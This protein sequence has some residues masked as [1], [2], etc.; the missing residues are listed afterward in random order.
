MAKQLTPAER[1]VL[2]KQNIDAAT[3]VVTS[4]T[5]G[6]AAH[7]GAVKDMLD[8]IP[9]VL[10]P[11][12]RLQHARAAGRFSAP[13]SPLATPPAAYLGLQVRAAQ[14]W[15][16]A[17]RAMAAHPHYVKQVDVEI[18]RT[19][20]LSHVGSLLLDT[21]KQTDAGILIANAIRR[22]APVVGPGRA[23]SRPGAHP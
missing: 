14:L 23:G 13:L 6:K 4:N 3:G 10:D 12:Q 1:D 21:A 18:Q 8:A 22:Q 16:E 5:Y 20:N 9:D 17:I 11:L 19:I 7:E 15:S 2:A